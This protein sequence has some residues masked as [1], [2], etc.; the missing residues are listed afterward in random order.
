MKGFG[1]YVKNNLLE[2]K[3]VKA[4]SGASI[5]LYLWLLDKMTSIT[6]E[7]IGKI[8][9]GKPIT[10]IMLQEELGIPGRTYHRWVDTLKKSGYIN[11]IRTP[12]GLS[13][14]VNKAEKI[15]GT[16]TELPKV[17]T[18]NDRKDKNGN[19]IEKSKYGN[20][21]IYNTAID[22]TIE[23]R[24]ILKKE[25][26]PLEKITEEVLEEVAAKYKLPLPFVKLQFE[27]MQN[28]LSARNKKYSNYKRGLMNFVLRAAEERVERG[29]KDD[30]YGYTDARKV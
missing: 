23:E 15:F 30:K 26:F 10:D 25:A 18:L 29:Q 8:L 1:I 12:Y 22:N 2:P 27:K 14:T 17:A 6:E 19:S 20:S 16:K 4:M 13:I 28:W 11:T 24:N 5:W 3:H 9:N 7:G 21:N